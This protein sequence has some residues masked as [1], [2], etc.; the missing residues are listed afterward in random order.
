VCYDV[1]W[2]FAQAGSLSALVSR[3]YTD[4]DAQ[5]QAYVGVFMYTF[6]SFVRSDRLL[7]ILCK[8]YKASTCA[9]ARA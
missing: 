3:L 9:C 4:A 6:R 1:Y 5:L 2:P 8:T 7:D